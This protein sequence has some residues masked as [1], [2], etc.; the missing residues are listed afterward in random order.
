MQVAAIDKT[1]RTATV[2]PCIDTSSQYQQ[3]STN[4]G[5]TGCSQRYT[6]RL[7]A[8]LPLSSTHASVDDDEHADGDNPH[9][10]DAGSSSGEDDGD[11]GSSSGG[12]DFDSEDEQALMGNG[13]AVVMGRDGRAGAGSWAGGDES[14]VADEEAEDEDAVEEACVHAGLGGELDMMG[15]AR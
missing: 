13:E 14:Q 1:T 3:S 12:S 7:D 15:H 4:R 2:A 11:G 10:R 6:V 5:S 9:H 8:V